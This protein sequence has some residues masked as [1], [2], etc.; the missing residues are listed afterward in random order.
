AQRQRL[1]AHDAAILNP[2]LRHERQYQVEKSL[3]QKRENRN[4]EQQRGKRPNHFNELLNREIDLAAEIA[5]DRAEQNAD[6]ARDE[7][8]GGG[9]GPRAGR[10]VDDAVKNTGA[11]IGRPEKVGAAE[12]LRRPQHRFERLMLRIVRR[13]P[14]AQDADEDERGD[15]DAARDDLERQPADAPRLARRDPRVSSGFEDR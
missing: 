3:T 13:E 15:D 8:D 2:A 9:Y 6:R 1:P 10:A 14:R 4:G 7:H 5:G 12:P 11:D